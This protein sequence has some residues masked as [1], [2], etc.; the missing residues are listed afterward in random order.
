MEYIKEKLK[1]H[2][3]NYGVY[4]EEMAQENGIIP[5]IDLSAAAV[6]LFLNIPILVVKT[7]FTHNPT[8]NKKEWFCVA[9]EAL[10][11]SKLN[12]H[13]YKIIVD[14]ND[15]FVG[16]T[17]PTPITHLKEDQISL[18]DNLKYAVE[19]TNIVLESVP[20]GTQFYKSTSRVL[21]YLTAAQELTSSADATTG[22]ASVTLLQP[23]VPVPPMQLGIPAKKENMQ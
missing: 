3:Y 21:N 11:P 6:Q 4:C 7:S 20:Q 1:Y 2:R 9:Q 5:H 13:K 15:E 17:S 18:L 8:T 19:A 12:I 22:T 23:T 14:N 10:G 16:A